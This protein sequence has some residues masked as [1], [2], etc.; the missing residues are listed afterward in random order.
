VLEQGLPAARLRTGVSA[1]DGLDARP[2]AGLPAGR[3]VFVGR[4]HPEKGPDVLVEALAL[5]ASPPP[6]VLVGA[7]PLERRLRRLVRIRGLEDLV[8]FTGWQQHPGEW[9]A[10]AGALAV[11][12]RHEAWSQAAVTAMGL[13]V[14]VVGSRVEGLPVTLG[15][16]RG[17]LVPADRPAALAQALE[18]VLSGD[19]AIDLAH[20]REYARRFSPEQVAATYAS[21]YRALVT[22]EQRAVAAAA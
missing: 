16:G 19:H 18:A 13:G 2:R 20:A 12:S 11:P 5:M 7:G 10:G 1:L 22:D 8:T 14:P 6:A 4:L 15:A 3:V 9:V 17:V 21:A